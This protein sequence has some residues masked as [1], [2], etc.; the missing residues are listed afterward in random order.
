[1]NATVNKA[2]I[3]SI[4]KYQPAARIKAD[5]S[6]WG[7]DKI[8]TVGTT[9]KPQVRYFPVTGLPLAQPRGEMEEMP[10][11]DFQELGETIFN[12]VKFLLG[13]RCSYELIEDNQN[14]DGMMK[15]E[16]DAMGES[17]AQVAAQYAS[18]PF[19]RGFATTYQ[20]MYD[21]GALF[22]SRT[23]PVDGSTYSNLL[24]AYAPDHDILW[25]ALNQ[26]VWQRKNHAGLLATDKAA[27][28]QCSWVKSPDWTR[29]LE[30]T[31]EPDTLDNDNFVK[32]YNLKLVV[33]PYLN[34]TSTWIIGGEKSKEDLVFLWKKRMKLDELY[35]DPDHRA[36]KQPS[37]SRFL[38]GVKE[39]LS[40]LGSPGL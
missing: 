28:L 10:Y 33:N 34:P 14:F 18:L 23:L 30:N 20:T 3:V 11:Y 17:H 13:F 39:F 4:M 7:W 31:K 9:N 32:G 36:V 21:G 29:I 8:Y 19:N 2:K 35:D 6:V 22:A 25:S 27:W 15:S 40:F 5:M 12:V 1:M 16:G 38:C 37:E 24:P 26:Y